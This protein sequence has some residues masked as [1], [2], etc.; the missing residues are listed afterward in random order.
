MD[1]LYPELIGLGNPPK[2]LL[3]RTQNLD[4]EQMH[5]EI[6]Q[7][8]QGSGKTRGGFLLDLFGTIGNMIK[9]GIEGK[10]WS[11]NTPFQGLGKSAPQKQKKEKKKRKLSDRQIKRNNLIRKLMRE[12]EGLT[13]PQASKYIKENNLV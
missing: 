7:L 9:N 10:R 13:L 1:M 8:F 6:E 3:G 5:D 2:G 12:N 11:D 4:K